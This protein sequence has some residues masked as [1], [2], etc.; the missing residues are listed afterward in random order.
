MKRL[1]ASGK[2]IRRLLMV[3]KASTLGRQQLA[4]RRL[5]CANLPYG[6]L[7][8]SKPSKDGLSVLGG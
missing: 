7:I 4:V 3:G 8:S 1:F 5:S 2:K 6:G